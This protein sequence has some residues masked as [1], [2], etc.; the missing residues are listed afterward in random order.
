MANL[1]EGADWKLDVLGV[2]EVQDQPQFS[3]WEEVNNK[4]EEKAFNK[5]FGIDTEKKHATIDPDDLYGLL[6]AP[7]DVTPVITLMITR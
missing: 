5:A 7:R 3:T 6:Q 1:V 2:P 4:L